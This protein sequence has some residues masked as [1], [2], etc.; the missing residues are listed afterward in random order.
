MIESLFT[1]DD[2]RNILFNVVSN[3]DSIEDWYAFLRLNKYCNIKANE[4]CIRKRVEHVEKRRFGQCELTIAYQ[5][6]AISDRYLIVNN[7]LEGHAMGWWCYGKRSP[8]YSYRFKKGVLQG[9]FITWFSPEVKSDDH[10]N[11]YMHFIDGE[12]DGMCMKWNND[13]AH[14]INH[15]TRY[16]NKVPVEQITVYGHPFSKMKSYAYPDFFLEAG[17]YLVT[18]LV[19]AIVDHDEIVS[20]R[21]HVV[22]ILIND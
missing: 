5:H 18:D 4:W 13:L 21:E 3:I 9:E 6:D 17:R 15:Q 7:V 12:P 1:S 10:R 20:S 14:L 2:F 11:L 19:I 8:K 16:C 22:N